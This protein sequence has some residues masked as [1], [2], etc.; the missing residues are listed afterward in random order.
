MS[1]TNVEQH[2]GYSVH[3]TSDKHDSGAWVGSFHIAKDNVPTIS[4]SLIDAMF[5][6]AEEAAS[7]ALRQGSV[8][9]DK[10]LS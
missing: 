4:I 10:E 8:Y 3:G 1:H 6:T 7:H 9:I 2:Q 5:D